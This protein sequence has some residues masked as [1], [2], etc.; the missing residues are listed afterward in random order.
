MMNIILI[1]DEPPILR[2]LMGHILKFKEN[3]TVKGAFTNAK[4]ALEYLQTNA[5]FIDVAI[6]DIELPVIN[7]LSFMKE[8]N[9]H[10]HHINCIIISGYNN[11]EYARSALRL[12][13]ADYLSKPVDIMDLHKCLLTLYEKKCMES[14]QQPLAET[15]TAV[16]GFSYNY[17]LAVICDGNYSYFNASPSSDHHNYEYK[18]RPKD[19]E[20]I[21]LPVAGI[22]YRTATGKSITETILFLHLE[23]KFSDIMDLKIRDFFAPLL[24]QETKFTVVYSKVPGRL[25]ETGAFLQEIRHC[26]YKS[27]VIG[28]TQLIHYIKG[29][30][31][32]PVFKPN[33]LDSELYHLERIFQEANLVLFRQDLQ[34]LLFHLEEQGYTQVMV[35]YYLNQLAYSCLVK[36]SKDRPNILIPELIDDVIFYSGNYRTLYEN[37]LS[38]FMDYLKNDNLNKQSTLEKINYYIEQHY[39]EPINT[40]HLADAFNFTPSY[41][42]KM[43]REYK[44]VSP[45]EY[46]LT[47]KIDKAKEL[48]KQNPTL[49]VKDCA[50]LVG[51]HDPLYFSKVFKKVT[52]LSPKQFIAQVT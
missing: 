11:F 51:Y 17:I 34:K 41:L 42:S 29:Q 10:Y 47:L 12:G 28:K 31:Q 48:L 21:L 5:S 35:F 23:Q 32:E 40:S 20:S 2:G 49:P 18:Y 3:F 4:E 7:G 26:L 6:T 38:V 9:L 19:L 22:R 46:I 36:Q 45:I 14:L 39:M 8:V 33:A 24:H 16:L 30:W 44:N 27:I 50:G 1:E 25:S 15:E 43:F 13:A 37:L 52:G